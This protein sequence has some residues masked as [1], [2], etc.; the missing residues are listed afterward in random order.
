MGIYG[1]GGEQDT[2]ATFQIRKLTLTYLKNR[3]EKYKCE[4]VFKLHA[5]R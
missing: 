4:F 5:K 2:S 3:S 1:F